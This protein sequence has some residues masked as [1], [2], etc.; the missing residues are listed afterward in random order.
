MHVD[1]LASLLEADFDVE[2]GGF[3]WW[4]DYDLDGAAVTGIMDYLD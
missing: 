3:T 2:R 4:H 1:E